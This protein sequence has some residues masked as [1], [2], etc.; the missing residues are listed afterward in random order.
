MLSVIRVNVVW[1]IVTAPFFMSMREKA[2][3]EKLM[4]MSKK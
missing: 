3:S 2:M 4:K 1:L